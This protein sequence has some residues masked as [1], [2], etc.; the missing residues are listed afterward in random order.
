MAPARETPFITQQLH[1]CLNET[2]IELTTD[3]WTRCK[4]TFCTIQTKVRVLVG[5]EVPHLMSSQRRRYS[6]IDNVS[7]LE[8]CDGG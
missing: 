8:G 6:V 1:S 4:T 2:G 5:Y 7:F 3:H